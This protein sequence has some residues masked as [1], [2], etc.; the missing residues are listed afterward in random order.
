MPAEAHIILI[1][2]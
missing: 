2:S 1:A